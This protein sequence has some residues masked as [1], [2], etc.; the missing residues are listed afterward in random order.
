MRPLLHLGHAGDQ[1]PIDLARRSRAEGL[2]QGRRGKAGL[3]DQEAAGSVLVEP[4]HQPRPLAVGVAQDVEH[5]VDMARGAG[6]ALHREPH[7]FVEHQHVGVLVQRD[8]FEERAGLF[9]GLAARRARLRL[10]EPERRNAHGLPRLQAVLRLRALAVD[11]HFTFTNDALD[12]GEAQARKLR[13]EEAI[14]A[15]AGF[16]GGDRDVLHGGWFSFLR[17]V[18]A[19]SGEVGRRRPPAFPVILR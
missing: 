19:R 15:H 2:G 4:M 5:A 10:F 7:R 3:G 16:V 12:V 1:R 13:F 14:D 8:R 9:I 18:I 11:P 17:Q 6:A